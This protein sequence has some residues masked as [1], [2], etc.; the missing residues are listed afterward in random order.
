MPICKRRSKHS[1]VHLSVPT[2]YCACQ[3]DV[4]A[5]ARGALLNTRLTGEATL[6]ANPASVP[7]AAIHTGGFYMG[8]V[9]QPDL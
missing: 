5:K 9:S 2:G 4:V 7:H 8:E 3:Q 1:L 6:P